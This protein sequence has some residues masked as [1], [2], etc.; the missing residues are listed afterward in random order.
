MTGYK[1]RVRERAIRDAAQDRIDTLYTSLAVRDR[2]T[3]S[4]ISRAERAAT[5]LAAAEATITRLRAE[6]RRVSRAHI[7]RCTGCG[8]WVPYRAT[9]TVCTILAG[10]ADD[11]AA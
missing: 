1:H 7:V 6:A 9:C 3:R 4:A 2:Q 11:R 8:D 5:E 10:L